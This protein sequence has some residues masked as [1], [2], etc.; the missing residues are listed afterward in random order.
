[1]YISVATNLVVQI[2]MVLFVALRGSVSRSESTKSRRV[3]LLLKKIAIVRV[4][5]ICIVLQSLHQ[6]LWV[7]PLSAVALS[8]WTCTRVEYGLWIGSSI[9]NYHLSVRELLDLLGTSNSIVFVQ[10]PLP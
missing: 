8:R 2:A 3:H 7:I 1:M 9:T 6:V 4:M 10:G 5:R